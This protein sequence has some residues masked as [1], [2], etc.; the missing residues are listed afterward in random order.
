MAEAQAVRGRA[1]VPAIGGARL[2]VLVAVM[3]LL[4]YTNALTAGFTLDDGP[5]IRENAAVVGGVD[6]IRILSS[7]LFPGDLYRPL[8]TFTFAVNERLTPGKPAAFHA[9][10]VAL[11]ASVTLLVLALAL[12]LFRSPPLAGTAA[13]L[14]AVHPIHTEAVTSLV[15]RAELLAGLFGLLALLTAVPGEAGESTGRRRLRQ[16]LSVTAFSLALFSKESALTFLP[17]IVLFRITCRGESLRHGFRHELRTLDWLPYALCAG[18]FLWLRT[19]V[20]GAVSAP[21]PI[22]PLNNMLAFVGWDVRLPSAI[23]ILWDYC[24]L[25][26]FPLVLSA[27]YSYDQV[28]LV[29]AW[30]DPRL[31]GGIGLIAG[32]LALTRHPCPAVRFAAAFPFI[33]LALTANVLFPIGTIKAERLLY[34]PSVGWVLLVAYALDRMVAAPHLRRAA[35]LG[36]VLVIAVLSA[37][38]WER[39]GDWQDD[40][41]LYRSMAR[42]APDSAKAVHDLGVVLQRQGAQPAA[43]AQFERALSIYPYPESAFGVALSYAKEGQVDEAARWY[44]KALAIAPDFD[45]AHTNLCY[46]LWEHRRFA[47]AVQACRE[48][49]RYTPTDGNLLKLLGFSFI[50]TGKTDAGVEV[51]RRAL[52]VGGADDE[53][54]QYVEQLASVRAA[55]DPPVPPG[56]TP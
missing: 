54:R 11:H 16:L 27:D 24:R 25:L 18:L 7:P 20:V 9:T 39:N 4:P 23:A 10:N 55:A 56:V 46:L 22:K 41:A 5:Q 29:H 49:L 52:I 40:L 12:R 48:A 37:R 28:P 15:G 35:T 33:A 53:L 36:L 42:A 34:V 3:A 50:G 44:G 30:T 31:L 19:A 13:A 14:F 1:A 38:T 8:T 2:A 43:I 32:A 6:V 45:K 17:L 47:D 21:L 51:L 26:S